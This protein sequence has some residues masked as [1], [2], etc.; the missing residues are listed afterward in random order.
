MAN[1]GSQNDAVVLVWK[2]VFS[3]LHTSIPENSV[4]ELLDWAALK[5]ISMDRETALDFSLW[6]ELRCTVRHELP[7]GEPAALELYKTWRSLFILLTALDC[8][9][10]AGSPISVMSDGGMSEGGP[11]DWA[12]GASDGGFGIT[13]PAPQAEPALA[14][15]AQSQ[16]SAAP[17]DPAPAEAGGSGQRQG[18]QP[19]L[20][21]G[22]TAAT[23]YPGPQISGLANWTPRAAPS[24]VPYA[25]GSNLAGVAP[26][27]PLPGL[28]GCAPLPSLALDCSAQSQNRTMDL[29]MQHLPFL[30]EL[31]NLSRR[32][33]DLLSL[34]ERRLPEPAPQAAPAPDVSSAPPA[35]PPPEAGAAAPSRETAQP[36]AKPETAL[37]QENPEA[38][39]AAAERWEEAAAP[40]EPAENGP[41][42]APGASVE[43]RPAVAP[44]ASAERRPET[45][46]PSA[47]G[48]RETAAEV[49]TAPNVAAVWETAAAPGA[50]VAP[51][52]ASA[53][54]PARSDL[55]EMASRKET[56]VKTAAQPAAVCP[57]CSGSGELSQ[58][59]SPPR[60]FLFPPSTPK[61]PLP[62]DSL[63]GSEADEV[64]APGRQAAVAARRRKRLRRS[65]P[66]TF[67]DCTVTLRPTHR[68]RFLESLKMQALGEGD[69]RLLGILGMPNRSE[70]SGGNRGAVTLHLQAVPEVQDG[71][72]SS[73]EIHAFPAYKALPDSGE[74]DKHEVIAWKVAQDL[75]SKVAQYGLGSAEVMQIIRVINTDLLQLVRENTNEEYR[76]IIDALPG[77]PEVTDMVKACAKRPQMTCTLILPNA[78]PPRIQ[79]RGLI[80][81][82][83]DETIISFSAWPPSWPLAPVGSAIA[84]LGGSTQS[85]LSERPVMVKDSEGHTA[86]IRPY[87]ATTPLNLWGRDMLAAWGIRIGTNF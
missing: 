56:A 22:W 72:G 79:L 25:P 34:L 45:A 11:A 59:A 47:P 85:Y 70:D 15:P 17:R 75:Q 64:L 30:A 24:S 14:D 66:W 52:S 84:G 63:S 73:K 18:A 2:G 43:N 26:G 60:T 10:R 16:D 67:P 42:A 83:A 76:K 81:T 46:A 54:V 78:R 32:M 50:A 53:S 5:G 68:N 41:A 39:A 57:V 31:R 44:G 38:A 8:D 80:D 13:P 40:G 7:T 37:P 20:P 4:R 33:E 65:R 23:A 77:D 82:G 28:P 27:V 51:E 35:P 36:A 86:M 48:E 61:L 12:S 1:R 74:H 87:V 9:S 71:T 55:A 49:A 58:S 3:I 62:D 21:F 19:A 6:Q 69:W 29:F